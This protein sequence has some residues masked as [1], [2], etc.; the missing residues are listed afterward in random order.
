MAIYQRADWLP[1]PENNTQGTIVPTTAIL[2]TAVDHPGDT[3]LRGFFGQSSVSVE[4][5]FFVK[6]GGGVE[7]YIDTLVRA[8]ANRRANAYA[9]SIETEDDG[10]PSRPWTVE[11]LVSIIDLLLWLNEVHDIPLT[12]CV[13]PE[14][15]G[16][17]WH[18]MWGAPSVW[19]PSRGKTCPGPVRIGQIESH[20]LPALAGSPVPQIEDDDMTLT[21]TERL[22][23]AYRETFNRPPTAGEIGDWCFWMLKPENT[24]EIAWGYF[25]WLL[26]EKVAAEKAGN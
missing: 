20:I 11:Q 13:S 26:Y 17:G 14:G 24:A 12:K 18:A 5:H 21:F 1:L 15:G 6:N 10:D 25:A 9:V 16:I 7:Q 4:S 23:A 22:R 3:S 8:D 19:T 2:H